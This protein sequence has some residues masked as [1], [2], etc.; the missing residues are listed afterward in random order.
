VDETN[1][2]DETDGTKQDAV[3]GI[4]EAR[5]PLR[6]RI[7][8]IPLRQAIGLFHDY[9]FNQGLLMF[10]TTAGVS[11]SKGVHERRFSRG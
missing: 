8:A 9:L 7:V 3:V 4:E 5:L 1:G 2:M 10:V 6:L 11:V